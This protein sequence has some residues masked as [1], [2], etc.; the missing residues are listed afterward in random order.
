ML[1]QVQEHLDAVRAV[2]GWCPASGAAQAPGR[3]GHENDASQHDLRHQRARELHA[4][5]ESQQRRLAQ[6]LER[7]T[8]L[9]AASEDKALIGGPPE[10][11][12]PVEPLVRSIRIPLWR[13]L[14]SEAAWSFASC[15]AHSC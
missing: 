13:K 1:R 8:D 7:S 11:S 14:I 4:T 15:L 2:R 3:A 9:L 6:A 12:G 5:V 10:I